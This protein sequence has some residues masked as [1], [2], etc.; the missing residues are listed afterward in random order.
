MNVKSLLATGLAAA[1]L[2]WTACSPSNRP[3]PVGQAGVVPA[4]TSTGAVYHVDNLNPAAADTNP[5]TVD[6]P[7]KTLAHAGS[8]KELKPGDTVLIHSGVY[9]EHAKITVSGTPGKPIT[10]AAARG[11]KVIIKGS[12][13]V[14]GWT[15]APSGRDDPKVAP[16]QE[17][18]T[19]WKVKLGEEFFTDKDYPGSYDNKA[20]RWVSQVFWQ[21]NHPLQMIGVDP[22]YR[23]DDGEHMLRMQNVG[24]GFDDLFV[25]SFYFDPA[26][27]ELYIFIAGDPSWFCIEVGVRGYLLTCVKVH[28]VTVRGLE[29]RH[30]RSPNQC[31]TAANINS[32]ER[33][34]FE[35]CRIE[36]ADFTGLAIGTCKN[37][38]VRRCDISNNG[39]IGINMGMTEDCTVED[40]SMM[41]NDYRK[42]YGTWGVA[43][44]SKNIPGNKRT[45][46]RHCEFAYNDALGL[47]FDTDNSDIRIVDNVVHHNTDCGIMFEIN[48]LG[49]AVIAGNLVYA[50]QGRGIYVAGSEN[51]YVVHNTVAD[52]D[53]GIVAMPYQ[54]PDAG[55]RHET[56]LNN[57][58]IHNYVGGAAV[59]R[60]CDLTLQ[61][62]PDPAWRAK[63]GSVCD[64]N[65]YADN[66]WAPTMRDNWNDDHTLAQWR[67]VYGFDLHSRSQFVDYRRLSDGFELLT[68]DG[69][70]PAA[71]LPAAVT[72]IWKPANA[73]HVGSA[74]TRWP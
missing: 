38:T 50:N 33:V 25:Q 72:N 24:K 31:G 10:F 44:G 13:V 8:A 66:G 23:S 15:R 27:G 3:G 67:Q 35:D 57:L 19:T 16:G 65:V 42:F 4:A 60:G 21:D 52:N 9:R 6:K 7:W 40:C 22:I 49:G 43:A 11:A 18:A 71:P 63:N 74:I 58:L 54:G 48:K 51:T 56:I 69:L 45:T 20:K 53:C 46:F 32:S 68:I 2:M 64:Y 70:P 30:N 14:T 34:V 1:L 5:G 61:T 29:M 26:K 62:M 55:T 17:P 41:R 47:W 28:D 73:G 36:W 39:C 59:T 37:C 12:E